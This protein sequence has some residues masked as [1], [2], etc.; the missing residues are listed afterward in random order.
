MTAIRTH[1]QIIQWRDHRPR[2]ETPHRRDY[3]RL[4]YWG[5]GFVLIFLSVAAL[6]VGMRGV[7]ALLAD[8]PYMK[9][10]GVIATAP[11]SSIAL[12]F[13]FVAYMPL[14]IPAVLIPVLLVTEVVA[15]WQRLV[16]TREEAHRV[17]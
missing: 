4:F 8:T 5:I 3:D 15:I 17:V 14:L 12:F 6:W 9:G 13:F 16:A 1:G 2:Q 11:L 7:E 10:D